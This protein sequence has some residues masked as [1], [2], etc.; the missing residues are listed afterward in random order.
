MMTRNRLFKC[1]LVSQIDGFAQGGGGHRAHRDA[2]YGP[3]TFAP[4]FLS[5]LRIKRIVTDMPGMLDIRLVASDYP[6]GISTR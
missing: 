6:D 2:P 5:G 4:R 1:E 3:V